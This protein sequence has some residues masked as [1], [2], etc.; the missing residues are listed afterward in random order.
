MLN[1]A[2]KFKRI[3]QTRYLGPATVVETD[4]DTGDICLSITTHP[5]TGYIWAQNAVPGQHLFKKDDTVLV[6]GENPDDLYVIGVLNQK[7]VNKSP[8]NMIA[9]SKGAHAEVDGE[10]SEQILRVFSP[11]K[12][13]IFQYD[14]KSGNARVNMEA[15]DIEFVTEEG[16]I[17]FAAS[18]EIMFHGRSIGMTG[19]KGV[20][21]G[22]L[23]SLGKL[24]N[25]LTLKDRGITIDSPELEIESE[26]GK[27]NIGDTKYTGQNLKGK[28]DRLESIAC[29]VITKAKNIYQTVEELSQ[30]KAGRMRT[31]VA[32]TFHFKSKKAF[33]KAEEDYK[34]NADKIHLG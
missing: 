31:M 26:R 32:K 18:K 30:V 6:V 15:G 8:D 14:E 17:T 7:D 4:A 29:T 22:V 19:I 28:I 1:L 5:Q 9:L 16:S 2:E 20:C 24:R 34:I 3:P 33:V 11:K 27:F 21:L 25:T 13:L 12:E 23:D 10:A